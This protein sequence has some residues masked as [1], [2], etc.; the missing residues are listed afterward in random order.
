MTQQEYN[1]LRKWWDK[2]ST[3][4]R[5]KIL[6]EVRV[7]DIFADATWMTLVSAEQEL[8]ARHTEAVKVLDKD[9]TAQTNITTSTTQSTFSKWLDR[10]FKHV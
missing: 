10:L 9:D 7:P 8:I 4:D 5:A 1:Q 2:L 6:R 3:K